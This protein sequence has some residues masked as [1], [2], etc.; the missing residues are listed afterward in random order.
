VR[1][2]GGGGGGGGGGSGG[3]SAGDG[4]GSAGDGGSAGGGGGAACARARAHKEAAP[5][6]R[7]WL[8]RDAH[9][10]AVLLLL[11]RRCRRARVCV[12]SAG[13]RARALGQRER[14]PTKKQHNPRAAEAAPPGCVRRRNFFEA[15]EADSG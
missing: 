7:G 11:Q 15:S 6:R 5:A 9:V 13:G 2:P 14:Q 4:G 10:R 1:V 3:G 12:R 8:M